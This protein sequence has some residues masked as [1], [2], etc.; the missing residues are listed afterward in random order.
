M[1]AGSGP[2]A[3]SLKQQ[4]LLTSP[5]LHPRSRS[6]QHPGPAVLGLINPTFLKNKKHR[7][8]PHFFSVNRLLNHEYLLVL[9]IHFIPWGLCLTKPVEN[10]LS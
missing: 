9:I 6:A 8:K 5:L 10:T 2:A 7:R 4:R 3:S 1:E